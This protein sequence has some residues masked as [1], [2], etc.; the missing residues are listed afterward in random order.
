MVDRYSIQNSLDTIKSTFSVEGNDNG[1]FVKMYNA[2]PTVNLPIITQTEPN[3][4][5][6]FTWGLMA[7]WSN[8]KAMSSKFFNV[9]FDELLTKRTYRSAVS[10]RRCVIIA[11][12]FFIWKTV[13]KKKKIPYYFFKTDHSPFAIAGVWEDPDEFDDH[14]IP[15]FIMVTHPASGELVDYQDDMPFIL[16]ETQRVSWLDDKSDIGIFEKFSLNEN[17]K[18]TTHSVSPHIS[19]PALNEPGLIQPSKP[20][21]QHGNYTLFG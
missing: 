13:A 10:E 17:I 15:N 1:E 18:L 14:A 7:K 19:N 5:Q 8:N 11:D 9:R 3:K 4:I 20:A 6:Y 12:G 21:D 16:D 2:A